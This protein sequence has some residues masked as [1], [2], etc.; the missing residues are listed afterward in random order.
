MPGNIRP[1]PILRITTPLGAE[2]FEVAA[3][4]G[5]EGVSRLFEFTVDLLAPQ[6]TAVPFDRLLG[7][8][9]TVSM[10]M[11]GKVKRY[12]NGI[13]SRITQGG[14]AAVE[15]DV[16]VTGYRMT[17]VPKLWLLTRR[18][19]SRIFQHL[20]VPDIL[21]QVLGGTDAAPQLQGAFEKRDFCVQYRETDFE[22]AS[23]LME[24]EGIYY[25]FKHADGQHSLVLGNAPTAHADV[26]GQTTIKYLASEGGI[27][28][29]DRIY[30]WDKEQALTAGK[31]TLWDH[32]FELPNKHLEAE[33][34]VMDT[35]QVG[36]VSHKLAVGNNSAL[37]LYDY[38]GGY[39]KRFDGVASGGAAQASEIQKIFQD[40]KR[41]VDLRM[42]AEEALAL[43]AH[44]ASTA[45]QIASGHK[46][47]LDDQGDGDGDYVVLEVEHEATSGSLVTAGSGSFLY[48]N[49]FACIP[50]ALPYRPP[51][52][53]PRPH[54]AGC[55]TAVVVGPAGEEIF[56]DK[57]GRVKVQF[58]WD[59]AGKNDASSSG[60]VRVATTWAGRNW[61]AIHLPRIGQEVVVDFLEGDPDRPIIVGS[62]YNADNMPPYTLPDN[63]TQSGIKSR[64]TLQGGTANF[65]ELRFE[66]KKGAEEIYLHA[67][68]DFTVMVENDEKRTVGRDRTT[69]ITRHCTT[70]L[71]NQP[72]DQPL[73]TGHQTLTI[74]KGNQTETLKEGNQVVTLEKGNQT[75]TLKDGNRTL[76]VKGTE[77]TTIKSD[78]K[79]TVTEGN[80]TIVVDKGNQKVQVKMGNDDLV[81][82]MGNYTMAV[83]MGNVAIKAD[84]GKVT[85]EAMQAIELKVGA[86]SIKIDQTGVQVKGIMTKIEGTA[87]AQMKSPMTQVN[88][89]GML[90]AKG[91]ITMI[92]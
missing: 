5:T 92:N 62:V 50:S 21:Q 32:T 67:E 58:H 46:F 18:R 43:R 81:V 41:T 61:G 52:V 56:V 14:T 45:P 84:L 6:T 71:K 16:S 91:G 38:P 80:Q 78:R 15:N 48:K 36:S 26:P 33:S 27:R 53:T 89:D 64:S 90:I 37:E 31:A 29:E 72:K 9:A 86:N 55:Q 1:D 60:W 49:R 77:T 68:K 51:Q 7:Q 8:P 76:D 73:D 88:G 23:R 25:F 57:Y 69:L 40:N 54:V 22:F 3:F 12:W 87:M 42:G 4:K 17:L 35:V 20:S 39:A 34:K 59:R 70:D 75:I 47:T 28:P 19:Q 13:V 82:D 2:T 24:E 44:G 85:I 74:H 66:D 79:V 30:L 11:P 65:N 10:L 83:K 63:K